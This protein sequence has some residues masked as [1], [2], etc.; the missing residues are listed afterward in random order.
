MIAW[1]AAMLVAGAVYAVWPG[2]GLARLMAPPAPRLPGWAHPLPGALSSRARWGV[3]GAAGLALAASGWGSTP[4]L[5]GLA[6]VVM[7]AGWL[8]LG[9]MEGGATRRARLAGQADLPYALDLIRLGLGAGQP[10]RA[11]VATTIEVMDASSVAVA[12]L[13]RVSRGLS[14]GLSDAQAWQTLGDDPV[15]GGVARDIARASDWGVALT[16]I[17]A[18]HATVARRQLTTDQVRA[19]KAV[20]VKA[21]APLGLCYLPAFICLGVVPV[22][23]GGVLAVFH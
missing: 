7:V 12:V 14:V 19:A 8:A 16:D 13:E 23:A 20:G 17:F 10:L 11:A 18:H 1:L 2:D 15:W 3:S 6:P 5:V 22:V 9:R 4:W 21:V